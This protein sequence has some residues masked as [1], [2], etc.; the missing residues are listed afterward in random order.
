MPETELEKIQPLNRKV[1]N[2]N[3]RSQ[4][5]NSSY[6]FRDNIEIHSGVKPILVSHIK[7]TK[8]FS[9]RYNKAIETHA[10]VLRIYPI[11]DL[12]GGIYNATSTKP[13]FV[14]GIG[15]G[16]DLHYKKLTFTIKALP[17]YSEQNGISDSSQVYYNQDFGTSRALASNIF[18]KSEILAAYKANKFFTFW[19]GYG[20]NTFGE[21]YRSLLLSDNAGPN[22]F[23]KIETTFAG[24]KYV[25]LYSMLKDNT[26][27]PFD[28]SFDTQKFTSTHYLSWNITKSI[29]FSVFETVVWQGKDTLTNRGLDI[30]YLNPIVFYRPVEYGLGSSDNVLIGANTSYKINNHHNIYGQFILD[31]FLLSELKAKSKWWANK[32]GYQL[33]YKSNHF[34]LENL[35]FQVEFNGVRPFTY[36]HKASEHSYGHL[37]APLAHPIGANF[38]E[39]LNIISYKRGKHRITN[40]ITIVSYGADSANGISYGQDI[41]KSYSLREGNFD[42]LMMQGIKTNVLNENIIYEYELWPEIDLFLIGAYNYRMA[43]TSLGTT[44]SHTFSI[45]LKSRIWN[46]YSDF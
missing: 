7:T 8:S 25:N 28:K 12:T 2:L 1:A 46:S 30:N 35:Y 29:N 42:Q 23:A 3:Y 19:G 31:E 21:G 27:N 18:L 6:L 14:A 17:Y 41:F 15:A 10:G 38:Y 44:H 43:N 22:P 36:S 13:I 40:K 39:I 11:A 37:N 4:I 32:Y 34:F 26:V 16:I 20:K 24:I 33:G 5:E 9:P 45:G